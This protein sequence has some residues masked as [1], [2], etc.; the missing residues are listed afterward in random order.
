V[1]QKRKE[2]READRERGDFQESCYLEKREKRCE[3]KSRCCLHLQKMTLQ[4]PEYLLDKSG[5]KEKLE[6][7]ELQN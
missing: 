5:E 6:K 7:R 2:K 4:S 1:E 3:K